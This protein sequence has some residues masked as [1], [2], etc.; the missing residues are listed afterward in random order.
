MVSWCD[1]PEIDLH[2]ECYKLV[3]ELS[4]RFLVNIDIGDEAIQELSEQLTIFSD[5]IFSLPY[6]IPGFGFYKVN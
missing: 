4:T 3:F 6:N 1:L 5:N 2:H